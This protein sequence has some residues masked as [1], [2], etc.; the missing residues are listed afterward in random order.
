VQCSIC[1]DQKLAVEAPNNISQPR[2]IGP[3]YKNSRPRILV[4]L[5]NPGSGKGYTQYQNMNSD[6]LKDYKAG[7][8]GIEEYLH[9]QRQDMKHWGHGRF[10]RFYQEWL[11]LDFEKVAFANIAWC[12]TEDNKYPSKMLKACFNK[13]TF[14]LVK[15]LVPNTILLSGERTWGFEKVLKETGPNINIV[16]A[17]HYANRK[18]EQ[19]NRKHISTVERQLQRIL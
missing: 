14:R 1:F 15:L 3:L 19:E 5:V 12:A 10:I 2:W 11:G 17:F 18:S 13:F 6:P 7:K 9:Y 4:L 16:K 8:T